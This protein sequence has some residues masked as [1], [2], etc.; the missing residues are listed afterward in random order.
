MI[1][2]FVFKAREIGQRLWVRTAL[3]SALA[4]VAPLIAP[5][6][7]A[8]V[9]ARLFDAIDTAQVRS[10]LDILANSML[11]VTT[12]SLTIMVT[13]HLAADQSASPRGHRLLQNDGRTQTVLATFVGSFV[14]ALVSIVA[15]QTGYLSKDA[16]G[17]Y[18]MM[19]LVVFGIVIVTILRWIG[20]LSSL[21]SIEATIASAEATARDALNTRAGSPFLGGH[22]LTPNKIPEAASSIA[23][24][25]GGYVQHIDS[26]KLSSLLEKKPATAYLAVLPGQFV[27]QGQA[28]AYVDADYFTDKDEAEMAACFT[29]GARRSFSQD[30][31]FALGVLTEI[32]ERALSPGINDPKTAVDVIGRLALLLD[33]FPGEKPQTSPK[34]P[35]IHVPSVDMTGLLMDVFEPVARAGAANPD[36]Q[37]CLQSALSRLASH[38][39]PEVSKASKMVSAHALAHS[40]DALLLI[41]DR[42]RVRAISSAELTASV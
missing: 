14:F 11:A 7:T 25:T 8:I 31:N 33:D 32:A 19:T 41:S 27:F 24:R 4:F 20:H 35:A 36:V 1:S 2:K 37:I 15:L 30:P 23:S 6:V 17:A 9:P 26:S 3:I 42:E 13:A 12:F 21:G 40:D 10:L 34:A 5:A 16:N 22:R 28:L 38:R 18:Y 39:D 29:L